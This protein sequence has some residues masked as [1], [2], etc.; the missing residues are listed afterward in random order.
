MKRR[1][2]LII[3]AVLIP[4]LLCGFICHFGTT[5]AVLSEHKE[6]L[7]CEEAALTCRK[8]AALKSL[9]DYAR[10]EEAMQIFINEKEKEIVFLSAIKDE[11]SGL[12]AELKEVR[13]A[14]LNAFSRYLPADSAPHPTKK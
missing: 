9:Q 8:E 14:F 1:F 4:L 7:E 5:A 13:E 6:D 12:R 2:V 11:V 3:A 10:F